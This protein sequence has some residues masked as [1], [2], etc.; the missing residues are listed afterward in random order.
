MDAANDCSCGSVACPSRWSRVEVVDCG[1]LKEGFNGAWVGA[2][3]G[4]DPDW[5]NG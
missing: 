4:G 3:R 2:D 5:G 1:P